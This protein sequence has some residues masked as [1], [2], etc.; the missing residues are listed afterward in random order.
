MPFGYG[1]GN[2]CLYVLDITL[3]SLIG[4]RPTKI[5]RP[6]SRRL[7]SKIPLCVDAYNKSLE[8][9]IVRHRLIKKLHE[10]HVS[11]W[12]QQEKA[13][14][15]CLIDRVGKEYMRHAKKVCRTIKCCRIPYSPEAPIWIRRAQVHY[16]LIKLHKGKIR[17]KGNL[18][19]VARRCNIS[20]PLGSSI[21]KI[22]LRVEECKRKCQFY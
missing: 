7:Y 9:N 18:K 11:N 20:K 5:I 15:V 19:W 2:H 22:L 3:E 14:R 6:A 21:T 8:D 16:S 1:V 17:N 12:T 4:K 10:V 13:C